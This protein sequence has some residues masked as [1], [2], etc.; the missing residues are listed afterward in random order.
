MDLIRSFLDVGPERSDILDFMNGE[1]LATYN[2]SAPNLAEFFK[3]IGPRVVDIDRA[4][5]LT[6]KQDGSADVLEL[7]CGNGRDAL[8]ILKRARNYTGIDYSDGMISLAHNLLPRADF[9]VEDMSEF[10]YPEEGYDIV[11]AFASLLHLD[12]E[13]IAKLMPKVATSLRSGGIFYISL[14]Y[15]DQYT[16]KTIEDQFGIRHFYFYHPDEI[17]VAG[18]N[19]FE[20]SIVSQEIRGS[21]RWFETALRK[22]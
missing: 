17:A 5:E 15:A 19:F 1:T 2:H 3:G 13:E 20:A 8:E 12:K 4:L 22:K 18:E 14:K 21:T 7:G 6:G 10:D 16:E 11:F 9:R